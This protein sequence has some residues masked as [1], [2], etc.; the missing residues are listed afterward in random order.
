MKTSAEEATTDQSSR[1]APLNLPATVGLGDGYD[2]VGGLARTGCFT[3]TEDVTPHNEFT[4][5]AF[6]SSVKE[7]IKEKLTI[8]GKVGLPED[9]APVEFT[10]ELES[11]YSTTRVRN[12]IA[13]VAYYKNA[14]HFV[15]SP[16]SAG[17]CTTGDL[18]HFVDTCGTDF[19]KGQLY[20]GAV[21]LWIDQSKLT[22]G[23]VSSLQARLGS[24][25][26]TNTIDL[27]SALGGLSSSM[28]GHSVRA[29]FHGIP[30]PGGAADGVFTL[31]DV[32]TWMSDTVKA[33]IDAQQTQK[34]FGSVIYSTLENYRVV[35]MEK[36][37]GTSL[38]ISQADWDC[39]WLGLDDLDNQARGR[40][41][42]TDRGQADWSVFSEAEA[43]AGSTLGVLSSGGTVLFG[44]N[45]QSDCP[46]DTDG[47]P[48]LEECGEA[49]LKDFEGKSKECR[50]SARKQVGECVKQLK[51]GATGS[52][53]NRLKCAHQ[54]VCTREMMVG[55]FS[56]LPTQMVVSSGAVPSALA[57]YKDFGPFVGANIGNFIDLGL[58]G[59]DYL[60]APSEF[61]GEYAHDSR[62]ALSG[63]SGGNW[64]AYVQSSRLSPDATHRPSMKVRCVPR[65]LFI[66]NAGESLRLSDF[67][68]SCYSNWCQTSVGAA[69]PSPEV[70]FFTGIGGHWS[71]PDIDATS[72]FDGMAQSQVR[73]TT[74]HDFEVRWSGGLSL[75]RDPRP[76]VTSFRQA[77]L[78][79]PR[80]FQ[81]NV[82]T[83]PLNRTLPVFSSDVG[84][85]PAT[86]FC[87]LSH[88]GGEF[89]IFELD[90]LSLGIA[91]AADGSPTWVVSAN[92]GFNGGD[93][94]N[95]RGTVQCIDYN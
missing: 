72:G 89:D 91:T 50:M 84:V 71:L 70:P 8:A 86:S 64:R 63:Y 53:E 10:T 15:R 66:H 69:S 87:F 55:A 75:Q 62:T 32:A 34:K 46:L 61:R 40:Q 11:Q 90:F 77:L 93:R 29:V 92:A 78:P 39:L 30:G 13:V 58:A 94:R 14:T 54:S 18:S 28:S 4:A 88:V 33:G 6:V 57:A 27:A 43:R 74:P 65:S 17:S 37:L 95:I 38:S 12:I 20:G 56:K 73:I 83:D 76:L 41:G 79:P 81:P 80:G 19:V 21:L 36:C 9:V 48:N 59:G 5:S 2:R 16:V 42:N 26:P 49:L 3:W 60:C 52:C 35:D 7:E 51:S 31:G 24:F 44:K 45:P 82:D 47:D 1:K 67:Q 68:V 85:S 22:P 25:R 23:E